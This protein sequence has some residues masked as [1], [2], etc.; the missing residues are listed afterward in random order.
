MV[1]LLHGMSEDVCDNEAIG[2]E[3]NH[4]PFFK[5]MIIRCPIRKTVWGP[6][7]TLNDLNNAIQKSGQPFG[8]DWSGPACEVN[9]SFP[10]DKTYY[11]YLGFGPHAGIDLPVATDTEIYAATSG[12]VSEI[13]DNVTRGIGVV[14]YDPIQHCKTV[15]WHLKSHS[16]NLGDTVTVGQ[17]IALSDNTGYSKG[18]HLHFE[19]K[20][21]DEHGVSSKPIDPIPHF[22][23]DNNM[24]QEEVKLQYALA[25]YR[26][27]D[28]D[29]LAF[30]SGKPLLLFLKT[31]IGDRANFLNSQ[32]T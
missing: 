11:Q 3:I 24:S 17:V 20:P 2:A 12:K 4:R 18:P 7:K 6:V 27:P 13:S 29:E 25:F 32:T 22:V 5:H 8:V 23:W 14:I 31:A 26:A 16:V 21:T 19:L 30:W 28:A 9:P 10:C 15:Y 1:V